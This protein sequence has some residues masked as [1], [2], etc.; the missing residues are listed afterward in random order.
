[1]EK[2]IVEKHILAMYLTASWEHIILYIPSFLLV[3]DFFGISFP[4][5]T[6]EIIY[7]AGAEQHSEQEAVDLGFE[8]YTIC[9]GVYNSV[10]IKDY[11]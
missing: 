2:F 3:V 5:R 9:Q 10:I 11:F 8:T 7:K 4:D 6:G 1:M